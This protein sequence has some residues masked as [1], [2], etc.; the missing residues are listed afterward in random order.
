VEGDS[1]LFVF[2]EYIAR[3]KNFVHDSTAPF[4]FL[5]FLAPARMIL[6]YPKNGEHVHCVVR[7]RA[8]ALSCILVR[9]NVWSETLM[10]S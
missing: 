5:L 6:Q 2:L 4:R 8:Y 10:H 7:A 9:V 3:Y 1:K